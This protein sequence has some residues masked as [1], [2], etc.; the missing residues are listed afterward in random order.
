M[1]YMAK[2]AQKKVFD[3]FFFSL[4]FYSI[5]NFLILLILFA[6][7]GFDGGEEAK[8]SAGSWLFQRF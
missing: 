3:F 1:E 5:F 4:G 7:L 8:K 2:K 6:L